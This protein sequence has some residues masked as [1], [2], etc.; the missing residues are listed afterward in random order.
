MAAATAW[1][2]CACR[3]EMLVTAGKIVQSTPRA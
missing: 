3:E 2:G 1:V